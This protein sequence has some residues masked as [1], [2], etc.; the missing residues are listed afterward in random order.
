MFAR[1]PMRITDFELHHEKHGAMSV[2][3]MYGV[4]SRLL[5]SH[6]RELALEVLTL[7]HPR[8][9]SSLLLFLV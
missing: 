8:E 9:S 3:N 1:P 7:Q 6:L 2:E 5:A 4:F